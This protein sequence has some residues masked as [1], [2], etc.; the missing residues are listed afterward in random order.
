[1]ESPNN[2]I[3]INFRPC[4][5]EQGRR[6]FWDNPWTSKST[7][8][9]YTKSLKAIMCQGA[10]IIHDSL[11][12]AKHCNKSADKVY[13]ILYVTNVGIT[14]NYYQQLNMLSKTS[15]G[16]AKLFIEQCENAIATW[17]RCLII[18]RQIAKALYIQSLEIEIQ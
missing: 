5:Y 7:D 12:R 8:L 15:P 18:W 16:T 9:Y 10:Q 14:K 13:F 11:A 4:P 1:M 3:V 2:T 6:D 17:E